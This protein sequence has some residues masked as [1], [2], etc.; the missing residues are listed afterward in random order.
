MVLHSV[1]SVSGHGGTCELPGVQEYRRN[2]R[3]HICCLEI[4]NQG[5]LR[6]RGMGKAVRQQLGM[7]S[8]LFSFPTRYFHFPFPSFPFL[9]ST[10]P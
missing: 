1:T 10:P 7:F 3:S 8:L 9:L 2:S 4:L 6:Q 5:T